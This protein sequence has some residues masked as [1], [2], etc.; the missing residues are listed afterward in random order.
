MSSPVTPNLT[1]PRARVLVRPT[2]ADL[3]ALIQLALPVM[4]AEM[5]LMAMHVVDT[6]FV[7]HLSTTALAAV[8]LALIYYFT[9]VTVGIGT[10]VGFDALVT[11]AV[12]AGDQPSVRRA[13]QRGL[14]LAAV[15]CVPLALVLWPT[16]PVLAALQQRPEIIPIATHVVHISILGLPGVLAFVVLRQT[17]QA[18]ERLRPILVA[19]LV[20]N[21]VNAGGNWLLIHGHLGAPAL[22]VSGSAIAS[23]IG[24]TTLPLVLLW[25]ARDVLWPLLRE[26]DALLFEVAPLVR[27]LR[28]GAPVGV[29]YL[30]EVGVFNAVALLMGVQATS[31]LAAHQVAINLA[32]FTFMMPLGIGA[33]AAV[34]VGQAI[35]RGDADAARRAAV[36]AITAGLFVSTLTSVIFLT[37]PRLLASA[38]VVEPAVIALAA[39]L[40]PLAGV[41][42][43]FDGVQAVA[44][45]AL[46]GAADT[47]AAMIANILG[48]WAIGLPLGL[49][50]AF[51]AGMGPAGLWWGLVAGLASV[52]IVLLVR[53]VARFGGPLV[54]VHVD[55][56]PG[57]TS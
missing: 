28:I 52:A 43:L 13:L 48:F 39:T 55:T 16:A 9:V 47:R 2:G 3:R 34:L 37:V 53:L 1:M 36:A 11:Q 6:L 56:T 57:A 30:L 26:R 12:G 41:F 24:R 7:G 15:L 20:A 25:S 18:M 14:L 33:A 50:L 35:G 23:V 4:T 51:R 54:R 42:Q 31:T 22:G 46:R 17:L 40:I 29:Q 5:G 38:Y 27:M 21:L 19:V 8:S 32:S 45:G 10:L 44:G 49:Y